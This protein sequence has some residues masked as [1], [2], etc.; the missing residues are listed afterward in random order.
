[1]FGW[2]LE[3]DRGSR[4]VRKSG[5]RLRLEELESR[6]VLSPP[7]P[8][9]QTLWADEF[10][11]TSLDTSKWA[12]ATGARRDAVNSASAVSVGGG[13]LTITTYTSSGTHYTGFI[14]TSSGLKA[15]YG[16]F[17]ASITFQDSPGEWSAF[18]DQSPTMGNPIGNPAVA[19]TEIDIDEHRVVDSG[20]A[21]V[22]NKVISTIHWDGYGA[23]HQSVSSGLV[24]NP[25]SSLQGNF[26]LYGLE[27]SPAGYTFYLDDT[28]YWS[29]SQAVSH[30][31]EFIYLT[32][33]VQNNSWAGHIPTGGYGSLASSQ[34]KM[35]VDYVRV[36][37]KPV[38][39]LSDKATTEGTTLSALPFNV[40]QKDGSTTTVSATS[41]N[42]LLVPN[43]NLTLGGSGADRTLTVRPVAGQTG[44]ATITVNAGN[45]I[46]SGNSTFVV[47]VNTGSFHNGG[48]EDDATGVGWNRYG[49]AQVVSG[50]QHSGSRSLRISGYGGAEQVVTGLQPN[51]TYTLGGYAKVTRS[52]TPADIGVKNYG[53]SQLTATITDTTYTRGTVTFTTGPDSTQA[54]VFGYKPTTTDDGYFDDYYLF[55]SPTLAP[56]FDQSINANATSAPI[57][58]TVGN[59]SST[60]GSWSVSA[61]SS[62][63]AVVPNGNIVVG[64]SGV[65]P[66][67]TITPAAGM[68]GTTTVTVTVTDSY[69][70][71]ARR[72]FIL[73]VLPAP[74]PS[75]TDQDIGNV[76]QAG[77]AGVQGTAYLIDGS[78]SD[79][80]GTADGFNFLY[81][82][83]TGDGAVVAQVTSVGNTDPQAKAGVMIRE[84]LDP[85]STHALVDVTPG[86]GVQFI[87]RTATGGASSNTWGDSVTAPYWVKLVRQGNTFTAWDG[88]DGVN[89]TL[90]DTDTI[91]M[92]ASV[93]VGL[94]VNSH[95]NSTL[96]ASTFDNVAVVSQVDLSASFNQIGA[97]GD[98]A[99][100]AGGLDGNGNAYSADSLGPIVT[101]SGVDFNLGAPG[102]NA[103]Q[104]QGQT[105]TLPP[106]QFSAFTFLG[107]AVN[108]AQT[109]QTFT[110]NY[111]DGTSDTFTQDMSDWQNFQGYTGET[112][113]AVMNYYNFADGSSPA[114]A[115][116]LYQYT[117]NLNKQKTVS[118][119]TL[120]QNGNVV[121]LAVDLLA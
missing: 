69:G 32:S 35:I 117:F 48:F 61:T 83:L 25:G 23:Y 28:P 76:G 6:F 103:V 111:T 66:S 53:G 38:S 63:Q 90:I 88:P 2:L 15:T 100:F 110:V 27:W 98:G 116:A 14:G 47:T 85:A 12:V 30:R 45:G 17:E 39:G 94:A 118:S 82:T 78:G 113:A 5:Y 34:T 49:G 92:A 43:G 7:G 71:S 105:I 79:I 3:R 31:S 114:G 96:N 75:W 44:F 33:E 68:T 26:H 50:N 57:P 16:Y 99:P 81:Q 52:G 97:T 102:T 20:G 121:I 40:T 107:T 18:W 112:I 22:S 74:D 29:T 36:W 11:G 119:V 4:R 72:Q 89:W 59:V 24:N 101:A 108:G 109:G 46:V 73:T 86:A 19:G 104:A 65:N 62:N 87:R 56:V 67:L 120:P 115:N 37:Q 60:A 42:T 13:N 51:T 84:T 91:P 21:N 58:L 54:T 106:G 64:G 55:R 93:Y 41:S 95:N 10:N 9:W 77:S 70:G 1:M 80:W 8:G